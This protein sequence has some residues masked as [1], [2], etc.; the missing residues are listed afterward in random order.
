MVLQALSL[1]ESLKT[2]PYK[3]PEELLIDMPPD[4]KEKL[5]KEDEENVSDWMKKKERLEAILQELESMNISE[6][7]T[8]M[9]EYLREVK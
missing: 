2:L 3:N 9:P 6:N 5:K 4:L 7:G 8:V 1:S